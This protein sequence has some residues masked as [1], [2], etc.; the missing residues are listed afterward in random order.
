LEAELIPL[1]DVSRALAAQQV[2]AVA[3]D[4]AEAGWL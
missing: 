2:G 3:D 4:P 1:L